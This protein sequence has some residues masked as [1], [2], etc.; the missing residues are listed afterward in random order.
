M[1]QPELTADISTYG[2][3]D[4]SHEPADLRQTRHRHA[5]GSLDTMS[6][7][8]DVEWAASESTQL[9]HAVD[10]RTVSFAE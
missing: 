2:A 9:A 3:R 6:R 4:G 8:E 1:P 5:L 7:R 10:A